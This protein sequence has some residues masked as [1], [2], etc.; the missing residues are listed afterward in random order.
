MSFG[1]K[2]IFGPKLIV[3]TAVVQWSN[4]HQ[5]V[6]KSPPQTVT[7]TWRKGLST[8]MILVESPLGN[9]SKVTG[10][11]KRLRR[12][13]HGQ[14]YHLI[15]IHHLRRSH[16][17]PVSCDLG[18]HDPEKDKWKRMDGCPKILQTM[19]LQEFPMTWCWPFLT[20]SLKYL[21]LISISSWFFFFTLY[22][23]INIKQLT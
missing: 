15:C 5:N 21:A 2:L 16:K 22:W 20:A 4:R 17:G 1:L 12:E 7:F 13:H 10:W 11:T 23:F 6:R 9:R 8:W 18:S 19:V 14:L 3:W